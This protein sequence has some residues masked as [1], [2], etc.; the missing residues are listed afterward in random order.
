M[1]QRQRRAGKL[2]I[3]KNV[4]AATAI[5]LIN[6]KKQQQNHAPYIIERYQRNMHARRDRAEQIQKT[7]REMHCIIDNI[8][9]SERSNNHITEKHQ[10]LATCQT[11]E[12]SR[13]HI[14]KSTRS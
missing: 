14:K 3:T 6:I 4:H 7:Q 1:Q 5:A 12:R 8:Q 10:K 11:P 13:K 9:K 2:T